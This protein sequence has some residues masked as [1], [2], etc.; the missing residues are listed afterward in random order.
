MLGSSTSTTSVPSPERILITVLD[1]WVTPVASVK[2]SS[3]PIVNRI[4]AGTSALCLR[5]RRRGVGLFAR[6]FLCGATIPVIELGPT[7]CNRA[8]QLAPELGANATARKRFLKEAQSAAAVG[9]AQVVSIF[10]VED[11][12]DTDARHLPYLAMEFID[13]FSLQQKLDNTGPLELKEI[14]RI[15]IRSPPASRPL[16]CR[17]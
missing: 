6:V 3:K 2:L 14:L 4:I 15:G 5:D 8:R 12:E 9:Q 13:G 10:A 11:G 7:S 1:I 17:D 16:I